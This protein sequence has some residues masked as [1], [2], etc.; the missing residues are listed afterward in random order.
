MIIFLLFV[1]KKRK[2]F[3]VLLKTYTQLMTV[4]NNSVTFFE[5]S[6]C[7]INNFSRLP[8]KVLKKQMKIVSVLT[9]STYNIPVDESK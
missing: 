8:N 1:F 4:S 6:H 3:P 7:S 9:M 5:H 2:Y